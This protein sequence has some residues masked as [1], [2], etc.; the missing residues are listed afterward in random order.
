MVIIIWTLRE[1]LR[2]EERRLGV[3]N[4]SDTVRPEGAVSI[5]RLKRQMLSIFSPKKGTDSAEI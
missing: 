1:K 4:T 2:T 3:S 5:L